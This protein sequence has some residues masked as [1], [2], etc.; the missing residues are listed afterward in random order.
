LRGEVEGIV[1]GAGANGL[2]AAA[3]LGRAGVRVLV[4][5][6]QD[7][8]GGLAG[9]FSFAPG[10]RCAP[11]ASDA[12]WV[13]PAVIRGLGLDGLER[14]A[15]R[16]GS[17]IAVV[18]EPGEFLVLP[19]DPAAAAAAIARYSTQDAAVWP[20]FTARLHAMAGFLEALYAG[21]P[22]DVDAATVAE[23]LPML[24]LARRFRGLG[25][26]G[27]VDLLRTLPMSV[28]QLCEESL[29]LE[30]L[31]AAVAACA[32]R[33][34]GLG[35]RA[36]GTGFLLLHGMTGAPRGAIGGRGAWAAGPDAFIASAE[37]VARG[38]GA[39]IRTGAR[40]TRITVDDDAVTG[41]VLET[42]ESVRA[43]LVLSSAD[44]AHTL[45]R[46]VDP[47]WL[48]PEFLLAVRNIRFRGTTAAV[49]Y[50]LDALPAIP[51]LDAAAL[52][53]TLS[54]TTGPD[55]LERA[56][57]AI[58]YGRLPEAPHI[59]ISLPTVHWPH[60]APP[61]RHILVARVQHIA[62]ALRD[63]AWDGARA[64]ALADCVTRAIEAVAPGFCAR[65][66]HRSVLTP[67]EIEQ[68]WGLTEGAITHGQMML[69]QILFMRPIAGWSRYAMPVDGLYLCGA[70]AHPGPGIPGGAGW[71]AGRRA[72]HD[73]KQRKRLARRSGAR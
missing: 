1:I 28:Q 33:D 18:V 4:L 45:L 42:G 8:V 57:D 53:G 39:T 25:R 17:T 13:L 72:L 26:A 40:V 55:A 60:L 63:G 22:P 56:A 21:P 19:P 15:A 67:R 10:F 48:D 59:E 2:V 65:V 29:T 43:P 20:G 11:F 70:G 50:A 3:A 68:R 37:R 36:G 47:V 6:A 49:L 54:L 58:K 35:P 51:G 61:G 66:L 38:V 64:E 5:E 46:L 32:I 7:E 27:M 71:L 16:D 12:G 30:P 23:L 14:A 9:A 41:V 52:R 62:H 73:T 24:G 31:Q 69:D 44:P 34:S